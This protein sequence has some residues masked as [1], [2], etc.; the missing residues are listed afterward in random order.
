MRIGVNIGINVMAIE[1][2]RLKE[3]GDKKFLNATVFIDPDNPDE[4]GQHGMVTQDLSREER[5]N[6][7][8]GSILGNVKVFW[9]DSGNVNPTPSEP[10]G[11]G[12]S[13][14]DTNCPF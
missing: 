5:D 10:Q 3:S 1:K 12:N 11:Q 7:V 6:G 9:N 8:K 14:E 13:P 4:H 2:A